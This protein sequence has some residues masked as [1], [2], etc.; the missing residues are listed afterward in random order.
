MYEAILLS[1][2]QPLET[3]YDKVKHENP[4]AEASSVLDSP[5]HMRE[6]EPLYAIRPIYLEILSAL[7]RF[8]P[9][10]HVINL[11]S[12]AALLG[13]GLVVLLWTAQPLQTALLMAAF[14]VLALGRMGTPDGLAAL[15]A[16]AAVWLIHARQQHVAGLVLLF[17]SLGVRTDNV[18]LLLAV[19]VWLFW[20]KRIP[21]YVFGLL[22]LLAI[23]IVMAINRSAGN[24]GWVVLFRFSF[25]GGRYP[26]QIPHTLTFREY[27]RAFLAGL[28]PALPQL[29]LWILIGVWAWLRRRSALLLI[30]T[31]TVIA[32]FLLFPSPEVRYLLWAGIIAAALLIRSFLD[33]EVRG[34]STRPQASLPSKPAA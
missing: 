23:G 19:L 12:A 17:L 5:Q 9:V 11:V 14:P 25:V 22:A 1:K 4:R 15:F 7:S 33:P 28:V 18:L 24:Y 2:T 13:I 31:G 10:Q 29:S 20:E 3:V 8:F 6:L 16:I 30:I 21:P 32:H 27:L 34:R 26:A